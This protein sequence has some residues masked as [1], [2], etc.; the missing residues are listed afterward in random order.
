LALRNRI[1][2]TQE[3]F[4]PAFT[5][6]PS[7]DLSVTPIPPY[8]MSDTSSNSSIVISRTA[9]PLSTISSESLLTIFTQPSPSALR[10]MHPRTPSPKP[11]SAL[12]ESDPG[13]F[14]QRI[15][16]SSNEDLSSK[17][18]C[19]SEETETYVTHTPLQNIFHI[20]FP[21]ISSDLN[22]PPCPSPVFF[23]SY[24]P[25]TIFAPSHSQYH[26]SVIATPVPYPL[27]RI[28]LW[29]IHGPKIKLG[30]GI[31]VQ[32]HFGQ[33]QILYLFHEDIEF[34]YF[35]CYTFDERYIFLSIPARWQRRWW[36]TL[37]FKY[38]MLR[39]RE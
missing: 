15:F 28:P 9:R 25:S 38:R 32:G 39:S 35:L 22:F 11:I 21:I 1:F 27:L 20:I 37:Q 4:H 31:L 33:G 6:R 14:Y 7:Y 2:G 18:S 29:E 3:S 30:P 19:S 24:Q 17:T 8:N 10:R 34:Y 16:G 12:Q 23:S 13:A 36:E 26:I 5:I